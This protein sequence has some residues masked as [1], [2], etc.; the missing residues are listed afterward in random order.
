MSNNRLQIFLL[1]QVNELTSNHMLSLKNKLEVHNVNIVTIN[2]KQRMLELC[3]LMNTYFFIR[4][5]NQTLITLDDEVI[6]IILEII[7]K[8]Y[9]HMSFLEFL[10][11]RY[12]LDETNI[13]ITNG[14]KPIVIIYNILGFES[15]LQEDNLAISVTTIFSG[16]S[17]YAIANNNKNIISRYRPL[18]LTYN[19]KI[20]EPIIDSIIECIFEVII[21]SISEVILS[22]RNLSKLNN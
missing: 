5:S 10:L 17:Y 20:I 13:L 9:P 19:D 6:N 2:L 4:S 8:Q 14:I 12:L 22:P 7:K 15:L 1:S 21:D 11:S 18:S 16:H 3:T